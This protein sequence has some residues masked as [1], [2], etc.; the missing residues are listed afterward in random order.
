MGNDGGSIAKRDELVRT[1]ACSDKADPDALRQALW[2]LC[3][4]S[5]QPLRSPVVADS[6]GRLY[7]KDALLQYLLSRNDRP[8]GGP[9]DIA[10]GHIRGLKDVV[11]LSLTNNPEYRPP[12][13]SES[14]AAP[15]LCPLTG[16]EMNGKHRFIYLSPCGCV[17]S[18][19]GV[20]AIASQDKTTDT[21]ARP[22]PICHTSFHA[23]ALIKGK[24]PEAGGQVVL[25]NPNKQQEQ[26]MRA[27]MDAA[28]AAKKNKK[29]NTHA[30]SPD[31]K[32]RSETTDRS[33]PTAPV[34]VEHDE[35]LTPSA[36]RARLAQE[37]RPSMSA[38][39]P[40]V[41]AA[42]KVAEFTK[43]QA[44][45]RRKPVSPAIASIYGAKSR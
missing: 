3:T 39:A 15:F 32:R 18:E 20:K 36:K 33:L 1:K 27:A 5:R 22:C 42:I 44:E 45:A 17:M 6:L 24:E 2:T 38:T 41:S 25:I 4:L 8:R 23:N 7:N 19:S 37:V 14:A 11:S 13:Q 9:D 12:S 10:A 26:E 21:D 35:S 16:K 43:Q 34:G 40:G 31:K 30:T 29:K 28:R